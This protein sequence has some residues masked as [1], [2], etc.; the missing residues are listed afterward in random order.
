MRLAKMCYSMS[1]NSFS[2]CRDYYL[3]GYSDPSTP[4]ASNSKYL[5]WPEQ[6]FN[7]SRQF[8]LHY[9]IIG[10]VYPCWC[11]LILER[12]LEPMQRFASFIR[13][14]G[15]RIRPWIRNWW[16][17][18]LPIEYLSLCDNDNARED[19]DGC[20]GVKRLDFCCAADDEAAETI[21]AIID[22]DWTT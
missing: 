12:L 5:Y 11:Y 10:L 9:C 1:W 14:F 19:D 3:V 8:C 17:C 21:V 13:G 6:T 4:R 7:C 16:E 22:Q 20:A 2:V 18:Y 15:C